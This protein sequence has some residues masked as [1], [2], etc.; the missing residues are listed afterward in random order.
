MQDPARHPSV[1]VAGASVLAGDRSG[2]AE[3][4]GIV[5][6]VKGTGLREASIVA[7]RAGELDAADGCVNLMIG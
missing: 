6:V 5:V 4:I 1:N 3:P 2:K 7:R